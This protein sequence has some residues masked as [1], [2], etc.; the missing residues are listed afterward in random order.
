ME[1][2]IKELESILYEELG[3]TI[4]KQ[5]IQEILLRLSVYEESDQ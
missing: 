3:N 4:S 5:L 1:N 2:Y